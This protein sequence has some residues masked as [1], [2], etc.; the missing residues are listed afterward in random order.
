[1]P[2]VA[3][4]RNGSASDSGHESEAE[5]ESGGEAVEPSPKSI[6]VRKTIRRIGVSAEQMSKKD[7]ESWQPPVYEKTDAER[8]DLH[9]MI[10]QS[11]DQK[12]NMLFGSV[13]AKTIEHVINA[14][15]A[16][17]VEKGKNVI[18]QGADGDFFYVVKSGYF[19]IFVS[20][21][22]MPAKKVWH[23]EKGFA[24]GELA[25]MYNAPR[26]ATITARDDS[27][28][29]A[30]DRTSFRMLVVKAQEQKFTE[31]LGF[32]RN[33]ELFKSMEEKEVQ[34]LVETLQEEDF[35]E[36]EAIL[37]Q[38]E[39]DDK[40]FILQSG[41]AVAC[42]SGSQGEVEVKHYTAGDYFGEIALLKGEPRKAS[43]YTC[44]KATCLYTDRLSFCRIL[45]PVSEILKRSMDTYGKYS[46]FMTQ[47]EDEPAE[48]TEDAPSPVH[49]PK[50]RVKKFRI[51]PHELRQ[52]GRKQTPEF[53]MTSNRHMN[54]EK[55]TEKSTEVTEMT[56]E[57]RIAADF[58][59]PTLVA[60]DEAW[61]V[62]DAIFSCFC[63]L[64]QGET[65]FDKKPFVVNS[66][67]EIIDE[68]DDFCTYQF[69]NPQY[70]L[71]GKSICAALCHKGQKSA[72]DPTPNQDNVFILTLK[73][74]I[75]IYGVCDGHGPFGHL[76]SLRIVQTIPYYLTTNSNFP[77]NM[78]I[79]IKEALANAQQDLVK[80]S[81]KEKLNFDGSGSTCSILMLEEQTIHV[82]WVGDSR[83]MLSSWNRHNSRLVQISGDHNPGLPEEKARI[84]SNGDPPGEVREVGPGDHRVFI[85]GE[86]FPGLAMSRAMGDFA[87]CSRGVTQEPSYYTIPM[88]PGDEYYAVIASDGMWEFLEGEQT[89]SLSAKKLRLKGPC[90]TIKF[91]VE[92]S[93][94]RWKHVE[95]DYCDDISGIVVQWNV[96]D[97]H[98]ATSHTVHV[99]NSDYT[100]PIL[101]ESKEDGSQRA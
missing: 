93:R 69:N 10:R 51:Q 97:K 39:R 41:T 86:T 3:K 38:G 40:M 42:I 81:Q 23:A 71:Q 82:A 100:E 88:Q 59:R 31:I 60:P 45:G 84:E 76:V 66:T 9:S 16:K 2:K 19:E 91:L 55:K 47:I 52:E 17:V 87:C 99:E 15:E 92:A 83:I 63:R 67:N 28:V 53:R 56:L 6:P 48:D 24:F 26:T 74:G 79:A 68:N 18:T 85:K 12:M 73:N 49:K 32:L 94:K 14:F 96:K 98:T 90:E 8:Q 77:K 11:K 13:P 20:K 30:L 72:T 22:E 54:F 78:E 37:E 62:P 7:E 27:E 44:E 50:V 65:F 1:M 4:V 101:V 43:V 33:C 58:S 25:L 29:W 36:G 80:F 46:E 61:K 70:T 21:N 75:D 35:E 95:G 64:Q 57:E 34:S 89:T 5:S